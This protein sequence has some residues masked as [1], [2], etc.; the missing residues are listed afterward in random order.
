[1]PMCRRFRIFV[2][3]A[4]TAGTVSCDAS[5]ISGVDAGH[6][7]RLARITSRSLTPVERTLLDIFV[8]LEEPA[9]RPR[10]PLLQKLFDLALDGPSV[11]SQ[12]GAEDMRRQHD[13]AV[14][15]AWAA[16]YE[17][18]RGPGERAL[19]EARVLQVRM[20]AEAMGP[21]AVR[22]YV[23]LLG[24]CLDHIENTPMKANEAA[25]GHM[26]DT[27]RNLA[28]DAGMAIAAGDMAQAIDIAEH[29]A[30]LVNALL[31]ATQPH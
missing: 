26:L 30:G 21:I 3:L 2:I 9:A 23:A 16:I 8:G 13:E 1:M 20:T 7:E 14:Q 4:L 12:D 19:V 22:A 18:D 27:A 15:R 29:A 31:S 10:L 17:G 24:V 6:I 25:H 28:A 5:G 11:H